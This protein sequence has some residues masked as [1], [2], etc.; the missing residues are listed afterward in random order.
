MAALTA[1]RRLS[2]DFCDVVDAVLVPLLP[3]LSALAKLRLSN[4]C[5]GEGQLLAL[6]QLPVLQALFL[7]QAAVDE[8]AHELAALTRVRSLKL[9]DCPG[10]DGA[11]LPV[12]VQTLLLRKVRL[13]DA[14]QW[15]TFTR[16]RRVELL[17]CEV[18]ERLLLDL[19]QLPTLRTVV[20]SRCGPVTRLHWTS[21]VECCVD[22]E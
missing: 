21:R 14:P 3:R 13:I 16:L 8:C 6:A 1:L 5:F 4:V 20:L 19:E 2:V 12:Q 10:V 7:S 9:L 18:A 22:G 17:G 11:H 15:R